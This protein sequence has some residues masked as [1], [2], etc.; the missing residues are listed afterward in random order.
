MAYEEL[1][2]RQSVMW[3]TG[4][5]QRVT[6][7]LPDIHDLI[8]ERLAP[9]EDT[10]W[11]DLACGTGA[12]A[13]RAAAFGARVT[14]IDLAPA[15]IETARERAAERRLEIDYRVGDCERLELDDASFDVVSSTCG[16]MFAPDHEATARELARVTRPGGV[17][18]LASWTPTGGLARMFGVMRPFLPAPPPANPFDWGDETRVHQLLGDAFALEIEEHVSTL[19]LPSGEAYWDLFSTSYGPTK[20]LADSLGDRREELHRAW[21]EF[22]ETQYRVNGEIQHTREYLLVVGERR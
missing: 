18:A 1:K 6:E 14:G 16:V 17:I 7:T 19:R 11:L 21:V 15:L 9:G 8:I 2:Q 4:P 20:V 3:G 22:F 13:E 10:D 12:V 5:Y